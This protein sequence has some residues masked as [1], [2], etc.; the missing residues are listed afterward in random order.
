VQDPELEADEELARV[1]HPSPAADAIEAEWYAHPRPSPWKA[2]YGRIQI[3]LDAP[4]ALLTMNAAKSTHFRTWAKLTAAWRDAMCERA[5][6]LEIPATTSR[7]GIEC[8]PHQAG[9]NLADPGAHMPCLKACIDGLRDAGVLA[10]DT[11][12]F[13]A[14]VMLHA[15]VKGPGA[16][17]V[18]DLVPVP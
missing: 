4:A 9:G 16:G 10:D 11:G 12:E 18:I 17:M 14:W 13:V 15:P 6:L 8:V 7:V 3:V 5:Q 2:A 1:L